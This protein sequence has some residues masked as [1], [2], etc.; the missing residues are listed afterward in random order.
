M[1]DMTGLAKILAP[2]TSTTKTWATTELYFDQTTTDHIQC[3]V[4][5]AAATT[6]LNDTTTPLRY[7]CIYIWIDL[8]LS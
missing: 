1:V 3:L 6:W 8:Y 7:V 2:Y 4:S 5:T